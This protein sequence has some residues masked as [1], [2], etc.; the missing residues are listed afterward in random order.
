MGPIILPDP[1]AAVKVLGELG[2]LNDRALDAKARYDA[3]KEATKQ[4]REKYDELAEQVIT[5]L[6][7]L[8][9]QYDNFTLTVYGQGSAKRR[10]LDL[11]WTPRIRLEQERVATT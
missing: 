5:R 7:E 8:S 2:H 10:L 6:R 3:L 11:A 4:S 1:A 9:R